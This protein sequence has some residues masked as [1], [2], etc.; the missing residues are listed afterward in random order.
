MWGPLDGYMPEATARAYLGD[1]PDAEL[2]LL[3]AG[4]WLLETSL[5]EAVHLTRDFLNRVHAAGLSS[6][7]ENVSPPARRRSG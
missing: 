4:H 3:D 2:H 1:L 6:Q 5:D 7:Q